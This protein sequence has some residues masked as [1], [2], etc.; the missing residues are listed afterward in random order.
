MPDCRDGW[1]RIRHAVQARRGNS[2]SSRGRKFISLAAGLALVLLA[3]SHAEAEGVYENVKNLAKDIVSYGTTLWG[4]SESEKVSA[5]LESILGVS[6]DFFS[7]KEAQENAPTEAWISKTK[8]DYQVKINDILEDVD[9]IL[10]D[11]AIVAGVREIRGLQVKIK[12]LESENAAVNERLVLAE[13]QK[14][15]EDVENY[16][17]DMKKLNGQIDEANQKIGLLEE[18]I[19]KRFAAM[20]LP[21]N[22]EQVRALC[23]RIDGD[24]IVKSI[25]M[26]DVL[27]KILVATQELMLKNSSQMAYT[28]KY[29][30]IYVILS[31]TVVYA[32]TKYIDFNQNKWLPEL[33]N[34]RQ[35]AEAVMQKT[36]AA[37]GS[38]TD[39]KKLEILDKNVQSNKLTIQVIDM[40]TRLLRSQREKVER[41]RKLALQDVAVA[42]S[43]YDTATISAQ[44]LETINKADR[45]F[46]GIMHLEIPDIVPFDNKLVMNEFVEITSKIQNLEQ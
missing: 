8:A 11:N 37:K 34:L 32:Q 33:A 23:L 13:F 36:A 39:P 27:K 24:D 5:K 3:C 45:S 46:D 43:S 29:Y 26:Y 25:A 21:M 12:N 4:K 42:W 17:K 14:H 28:K 22:R 38:I 6:E 2:R 19:Q 9:G 7:L 44:L 41:A 1:G 18:I 40:Y 10:C 35:A 31:E 15:N 20:G 30:G 16:R